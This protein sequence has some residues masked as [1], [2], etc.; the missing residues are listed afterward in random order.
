MYIGTETV[1]THLRAQFTKFALDENPRPNKRAR[2]V[3]RA[4]LSGVVTDR[5]L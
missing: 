3:E 5:D 4:M 2:L 1:K